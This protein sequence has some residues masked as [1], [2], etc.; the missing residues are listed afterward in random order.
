MN[1]PDENTNTTVIPSSI[2]AAY[3]H[4]VTANPAEEVAERGSTGQ[5]SAQ[6]QGIDE[7]PDQ[8][9]GFDPVAPGDR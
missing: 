9:L 5:I 1:N 2:P 6:H 3:Q 7:E 8:I 4:T